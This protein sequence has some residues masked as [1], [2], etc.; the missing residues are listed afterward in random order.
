M[1]GRPPMSPGGA[2]RTHTSARGDGETSDL[3][4]RGERDRKQSGAPEALLPPPRSSTFSRSWRCHGLRAPEP[5]LHGG[6]GDPDL[7]ALHRLARETPIRG[8]AHSAAPCRVSFCTKPFNPN[9]GLGA[10]N[11]LS[12][13]RGNL[14]PPF[15]R[16][17]RKRLF[18]ENSLYSRNRVCVCMGG[19][20]GE[21]FDSRVGLVPLPVPPSKKA[22]PS[23][24]SDSRTKRICLPA[25]R[26]GENSGARLNAP[27]REGGRT[28][29]AQRK[30]VGGA[31]STLG[32]SSQQPPQVPEAQGGV[33]KPPTH[34][35]TLGGSFQVATARACCRRLQFASVPFPDPWLFLQT[36]KN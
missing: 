22:V 1:A 29:P 13:L 16:L 24:V 18:H 7:E 17:V 10:G 30:Q 11:Q 20:E 34:T 4:R 23:G 15:R 27:P 28:I 36:V 9:S 33:S 3:A 6:G 8:G 31:A 12:K 19:G 2:L 5:K 26:P 21:K 25:G 35:P 14:T 32:R